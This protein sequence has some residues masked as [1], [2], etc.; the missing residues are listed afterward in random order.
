M[1]KFDDL[2]GIEPIA[3]IGMSCRFPGAENIN[4]FWN[5]LKTGKESVTFFTDDELLNAGIDRDLI[6]D[7]A[8]VKAGC[9]I[10]SIDQFD[11]T[12]FNYSETEAELIDPQQRILLECAYEAFEDAGYLPQ[13]YDGD[14]GVFGG[15]MTS[16]YTSILRPIFKQTETLRSFEAML[17]TS[18]D[19]ACLRISHALNLRGP[20][21]GIQTACS[22]SLVATHM[23]S[24][25]LR[26]RECDM[27]LSGAST[28]YI[29]QIQGYLHDGGTLI[30]P[31][32]HCR[33]FD[34]NAQGTIVGNGGG[35]VLLKRLSDAL[36]DQD[37]IYAIIR[38]S[39]VNNDGSS[40]A[41][42]RAPSIDGQ[43][44]VIE[45]ALLI[46]NLNAETITYIEANGTGTFY[47]DQIEIE[48]LT[49]AFRTQTNKKQ[50]CGLG[51][52]KTN[53]GHLAIAAGIAS[54]IKTALLLKNKQLVPSLNYSASNPGF[55]KTPFYIV[56]ETLDWRE[57]SN[58]R[59]AGINSFATG[60]TNAHL[61]LEEAPSISQSLKKN[62]SSFHHIFTISAKSEDALKN[63]ILRYKT[64]LNF[65]LESSIEN[66]CFTS[67]IGR[68]H[69]PFR[70]SAV[71]DSKEQLYDLIDAFCTKKKILPGFA[72]YSK[73]F[74]RPKIAFIFSDIYNEFI[75]INRFFYDNHSKFKESIDQC[76]TILKTYN[77][78]NLFFELFKESENSIKAYAPTTIFAIE[79]ALFNMF[80]SW[81]ILPSVVMGHGIGEYVAACVEGVYNVED[82]LRLIIDNENMTP[83][84]EKNC[85]SCSLKKTTPKV[86]K[87]SSISEKCFGDAKRLSLTTETYDQ[88]D[89]DQK[90]ITP[91][92]YYNVKWDYFQKQNINCFI[93]IGPDKKNL[94][95]FQENHLVKHVILINSFKGDQNE[96]Q[97]I[98]NG[99]G[100]LYVQGLDINW[101]KLTE[102]YSY[103]RI[104]LP[105]YP[106]EKKQC[107]FNG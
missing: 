56:K 78:E 5:N 103:Q 105:T 12:F 98:L 55:E 57:N 35:M 53:I 48:A 17:G 60:G 65:N 26:N 36:E 59:R 41:G 81:G 29:P 102:K 71:A 91:P 14:I 95:I 97:M 84:K 50:F 86:P 37:H 74:K 54:L 23:A 100:K 43:K 38:G 70:V 9:I 32:G 92:Q 66:I 44:R 8:Y 61:I 52:V 20:S 90:L 16:G 82:S 87:I 96:W 99:L 22:T 7:P 1:N 30:S 62:E 58:P 28:I 4:E 18:V 49:E 31:D 107:W 3:I 77:E 85:K 89:L 10:E 93:I 42:Y 21:I 34:V 13:K 11:F 106:F 104:S 75:P 83:N 63:M 69:Y 68:S 2:E 47:G 40:K 46:S 76:A 39:A 24:E 64:Y 67:N 101:N 33:A 45:E 27:A 51:S 6:N 15:M 94:N 72:R 79:Y 88:E 73:K 25:S 80:N 19:Q